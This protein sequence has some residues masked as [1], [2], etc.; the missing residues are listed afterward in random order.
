M[1]TDS[2][3]KKRAPRR[4]LGADPAGASRQPD[5]PEPFDPANPPN[6]FSP[7]DPTSPPVPPNPTVPGTAADPRAIFLYAS[8]LLAAISLFLYFAFG[9][10][11]K[12][13]IP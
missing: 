6:S 13:Y 11:A 8:L 9:V 1:S 7:L 12:Y 10:G 2:R 4:S 3:K 5:L